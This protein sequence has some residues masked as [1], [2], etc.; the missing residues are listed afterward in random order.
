MSETISV[1]DFED[2]S[3]H[4]ENIRGLAGMLSAAD[5]NDLTGHELMTVTNLIMDE[6]KR[7]EALLPREEAYEEGAETV[8][9]LQMADKTRRRIMSRI[10]QVVE[11]H[12][13][14]EGPFKLMD[15]DCAFNAAMNELRALA[16]LMRGYGSFEDD[17]LDGEEVTNLGHVVH[18]ISNRLEG[19]YDALSRE[20]DSKV[21]SADDEH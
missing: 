8:T 18:G 14:V 20:Y 19:A 5:V 3:E 2:A 1:S 21:Q 12:A 13:S 16:S 9:D 10:R 17:T 6:A 4:L 7:A 11:A 15:N